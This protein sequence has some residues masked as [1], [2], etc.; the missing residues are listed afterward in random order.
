MICR[1][2]RARLMVDLKSRPAFAER[3]IAQQSATRYILL[4]RYILQLE[5]WKNREILRDSIF[6]FIQRQDTSY[7]NFLANVLFKLMSL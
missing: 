6:F 4:C 5:C 1:I 3:N 7:E 2:H